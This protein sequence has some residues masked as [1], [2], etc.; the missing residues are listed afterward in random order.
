MEIK[1]G[2]GLENKIHIT[3]VVKCDPELHEP[4]WKSVT[5]EFSKL[6]YNLVFPKIT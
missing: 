1:S 5:I 6:Q 4:I 2:F 3:N